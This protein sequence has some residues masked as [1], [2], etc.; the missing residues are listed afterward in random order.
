MVIPANVEA[1]MQLVEDYNGVFYLDLRSTS[2]PI[3]RTMSKQYFISMEVAHFLRTIYVYTSITEHYNGFFPERLTHECSTF[4]DSIMRIFFAEPEEFYSL[5]FN[6]DEDKFIP[7]SR[8]D[9]CKILDTEGDISASFKSILHALER[10]YQSKKQD[11]EIDSRE[12]YT[13]FLSQLRLYKK[14]EGL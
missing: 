12:L 2:I 1:A 3:P 6:K 8:V 13:D 4:H 10:V 7:V 11:T 5:G 14:P 9:V